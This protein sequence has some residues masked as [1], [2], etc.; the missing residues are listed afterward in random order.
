MIVVVIVDVVSIVT[1]VPLAGEPLTG[2]PD[3]AELAY[4]VMVL[5]IVEVEWLVVV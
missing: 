4:T 5:K 3:G 1:M 2:H